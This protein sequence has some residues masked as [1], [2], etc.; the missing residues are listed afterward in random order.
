M[1]YDRLILTSVKETMEVVEEV[2]E[3][4]FQ[5]NTDDIYQ[6]LLEISDKLGLI[7]DKL[8]GLQE[9]GSGILLL[10]QSS[11]LDAAVAFLFILVCFEIMRL[12]RGWTKGEK[13]IGRNS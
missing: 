13:F 2:V 3:E 4:V 5:Y 10:L 9:T 1:V 12:V 11:F 6:V 8:D 7:N